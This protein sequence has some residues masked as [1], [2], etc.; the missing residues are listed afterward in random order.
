MNAPQARKPPEHKL[1]AGQSE[2]GSPIPSFTSPP[3][4]EVAVAVSFLPLGKLTL[5]GMADLWRD[6]LAT[7]FPRTEEHP[8]LIPPVEPFNGPGPTLSLPQFSMESGFPMPRLWFLTDDGEELLQI[9]R[10]WFACNW[11]KVSPDSEYGRW[12]SR[13]AA[14]EKWL[15]ILTSFIAERNLGE[16]HPLQCE[17]TYVNHIVGFPHGQLDR[18]TPLAGQAQGGFLPA[19][20]QMEL[21]VHYVITNELGDRLGRLHIV[22]QPGFRRG[23]NVPIVVFTIT[24]RG[25]PEGDGVEGVLAFL[26]RGRQWADYGF[27][28]ATTDFIQRQWGRRG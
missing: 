5:M 8:P 12:P 21:S 25:K 7:H 13:R 17:L 27:V 22:A 1:D 18:V 3:V 24:A 6:E 16:F 15:G 14:F 10:D 20:E 23:D 28:E 2:T 26:D 9:Q 4:T 11:R 19:P